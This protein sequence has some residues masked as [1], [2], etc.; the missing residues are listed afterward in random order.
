MNDIRD[1]QSYDYQ[2]TLPDT[3]EAPNLYGVNYKNQFPLLK[4]MVDITDSHNEPGCESTCSQLVDVS[5]P[6]TVYDYNSCMLSCQTGGTSGGII[7]SKKY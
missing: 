7:L 2:G 3:Y 4:Y 1:I 5:Q 6:N